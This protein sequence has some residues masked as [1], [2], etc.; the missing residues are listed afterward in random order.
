[1]RRRS[2][3]ARWNS[4]LQ[5]PEFLG[6]PWLI[7][8][9]SFRAPQAAMAL[10]TRKHRATSR[11]LSGRAD[12]DVEQKTGKGWTGSSWAPFNELDEPKNYLEEPKSYLS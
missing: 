9:H 4:C 12:S 10:A 8:A 2:P 11:A 3:E 5:T 1:M 6:R 7:R